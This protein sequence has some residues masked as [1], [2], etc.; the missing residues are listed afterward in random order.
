MGQD[1]QMPQDWT[2]AKKGALYGWPLGGNDDI[3]CTG[4][5]NEPEYGSGVDMGD[6]QDVGL[7]SGLQRERYIWDFACWEFLL[8]LRDLVFWIF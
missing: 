8:L 4:T 7:R 6:G 1:G 5:W 3:M 2:D